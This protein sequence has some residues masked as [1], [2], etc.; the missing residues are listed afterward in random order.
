MACKGLS[1]EENMKYFNEIP[2][3][4]SFSSERSSE[5]EECLP[6]QFPFEVA[7]SN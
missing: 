5:D 3:D 4:E 7:S 2:S 6:H 1:A